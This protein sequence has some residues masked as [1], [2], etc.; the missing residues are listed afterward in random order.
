MEASDTIHET[1]HDAAI[2]RSAA[3]RAAPGGALPKRAA[4][5][6]GA[7]VFDACMG[8]VLMLAISVAVGV[9]WGIANGVAGNGTATLA[10]DTMSLLW[11]TALGTGGAAVIVYLW[12]RRATPAERAASLAA[13]RRPGTWGWAALVAGAVFLATSAAQWLMGQGGIQAEPT[14]VQVIQDGLALNPVQVLLFAV[15]VAPVY[16]E[17]FFRR[18]LF[19][20]LWA[21]GKP[22]LGILLSSAVF[23]LMHEVP[24]VGGNPLEAT[25]LLWVVYGGMGAAF[26]WVYW[27]TGTLWAA[28]G[29]HALN[30]LVSCL[31]LFATT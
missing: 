4:S 30:N 16:E 14:N 24:G 11:M 7:F 12:R 26:A 9:A 25:L 15:V 28:I 23:A 31:I 5:P 29:A 22:W 2:D 3:D 27:K 19:G 6:L 18:V 17:L 8:I 10:M 20:R 1:I 13:A 21:A